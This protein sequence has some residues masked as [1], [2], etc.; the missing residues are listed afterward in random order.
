[1]FDLL[2][3]IFVRVDDQ[4]VRLSVREVLFLQADNNRTQIHIEG[5]QWT[6]AKLLKDLLSEAPLASL[7]RVHRS[8][9]VNM[10]Q[11]TAVAEGSLH[12]GNIR[13]PVGRSYRKEVLDRL[14]LV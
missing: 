13:V 4:W 11:V 3:S 7:V 12:L 5:R 14:C 8:Y 9:A 10:D 6:S 1:M 2:G